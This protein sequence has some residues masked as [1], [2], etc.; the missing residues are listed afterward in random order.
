MDHLR[1]TLRPPCSAKGWTFHRF[2]PHSR[3]KRIGKKNNGHLDVWILRRY[4]ISKHEIHLHQHINMY[5]LDI[6][7]YMSDW[8]NACSSKCALNIWRCK[9]QTNATRS[10]FFTWV[11]MVCLFCM[12]SQIQCYSSI[13]PRMARWNPSILVYVYHICLCFGFIIWLYHPPYIG[14]CKLVG[15]P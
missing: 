5:G 13:W 12:L 1:E 14:A 11:K 8:I 15:F 4:V 2:R 7:L 3:P 6:K 9:Q 10:S